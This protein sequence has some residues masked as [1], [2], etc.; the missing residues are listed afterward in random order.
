M[1]KNTP[2][3][4]VNAML[5]AS[6]VVIKDDNVI[7]ELKYM[8]TK[9]K[10]IDRTTKLH[11]W[12]ENN[13]TEYILH[14][15]GEF[16]EKDSGFA[17]SRILNL[18]ININKYEPLA[19]GSCCVDLP[20]E[21]ADKKACINVKNNDKKCFLYAILASRHSSKTKNPQRPKFYKKYLDDLNCQ[22]L[23]FPISTN[24]IPKFEKLNN[25]SVNVLE[26]VLKSN[27]VDQVGHFVTQ[28]LYISKF[29]F[30]EIVNLLLV[31]DKYSIEKDTN[32]YNDT[33]DENEDDNEFKIKYHYVWI[34]NLSRLLGKQHSKTTN[35]VHYC[36][37]CLNG[38]SSAHCLQ[39]HSID[40]AQLNKC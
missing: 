38:F 24:Q 27:K 15:L 28:T 13:V 29:S 14:E 9:S 6:F 16:Q 11:D 25:I 10:I 23:T 34:K 7:E 35:T 36:I 4:K 22:N 1:L 26:L 8:N 31:Q 20:K 5:C 37:R 33:D 32:N 39:K 2:M 17:L 19:N 21:I 12:F 30:D 3:F 40:C 18:V